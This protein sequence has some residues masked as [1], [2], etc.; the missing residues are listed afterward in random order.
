MSERGKITIGIGVDSGQAIEGLEDL[1]SSLNGLADDTESFGDIVTQEFENVDDATKES[2]EKLKKN[3]KKTQE[4]LQKTGNQAKKTGKDIKK[5]ADNSVKGLDDLKDTAG[6]SSSAM[7]GIAGAVSVVNPELGT[8]ISNSSAL[9]GG[10]EGAA[11]G[12]GMMRTAASVLTSPVGLVA[13]G[14]LAAGAALW[15]FSKR[16]KGAKI[17]S[18]ELAGAIDALDAA[19][20]RFM[21]TKIELSVLRGQT[22]QL[23]AELENL[24]STIEDEFAD[25]LKEANDP[26][27]SFVDEV[28]QA[29]TAYRDFTNSPSWK[30][31]GINM[32]MS[33]TE[34]KRL[35]DREQEL[36]ERRLK[37][38]RALEA[39]QAGESKAAR[40]RRELI[41]GIEEE[42]KRR[43]EILKL[44]IAADE[45]SRQQSKLLRAQAS[46]DRD[47]IRSVSYE[48]AVQGDTV[49]TNRLVWAKWAEERAKEFR[50]VGG[51]F[52]GMA[53]T[54]AFFLEESAKAI[55]E[56]IE[57]QTEFSTILQENLRGM[58]SSI[59]AT[60]R[61]AESE[62]NLAE[63][64]KLA[65]D[66]IAQARGDLAMIDREY[67]KQIMEINALRAA[68]A[69]SESETAELIQSAI[70]QR[71]AAEQ[72]FHDEK[73]TRADEE[74]AMI[75]ETVAL[76]KSQTQII[77]DE[78]DE[79]FEAARS[80]WEKQLVTFE[81]F[82]AKIE[83]LEKDKNARIFEAQRQAA[84]KQIA[85]VAMVGQ[86]ISSTVGAFSQMMLQDLKN[87]EQEALE[88]AGDNL[89]KQE[90]IKAEFEKKRQREMARVFKVQKGV[91]IAN[92]GINAASA[93]IA[94]LG[95][96]PTGLGPVLGPLLIPFIAATAAAQ[97]ATIAAQKPSFHQGGIVGGGPGDQPIM[98]QAGEVVL[99]RSAVASMGGAE[100]A[101]QLNEGGGP[102]RPVVVQMTYK[103]RVF[104]QIVVDNLAKGGPLKNALNKAKNRGKR[105]RVGG[106]L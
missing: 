56:E 12:M 14:V 5:S 70:D 96:P 54:M 90:K 65:A 83:E 1:Q 78:Y 9:A 26:F 67:A 50:E 86:T 102:G 93:S 40:V 3:Q 34:Q 22:T 11:K 79:Q 10:V 45:K 7:S 39:A 62:S 13:V 15:T 57:T 55:R 43:R 46:N 106:R 47:S 41:A 24:S 94:A 68:G 98:A 49:L 58:Q 18:N 61:K 31:L 36:T 84:E 101:N 81:E 23:K 104:D 42:E 44:R 99:S 64:T 75:A 28:K 88:A 66:M 105:G 69:I 37:A 91:E 29:N 80:N 4:A 2:A 103:N 19:Q 20:K 27:Q 100:A 21:S 92:V 25:A 85:T 76:T 52:S 17:D 63:Q 95:P 8:M 38:L 32:Q 59:D 72:A 87:E 89:D 73:Q 74:A 6:D 48:M 82:K 30:K 71:S 33:Q 16:S 51:A 35:I 97:I 60:D 77:Q 53:G